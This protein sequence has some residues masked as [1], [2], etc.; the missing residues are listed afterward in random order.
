MSILRFQLYQFLD[1]PNSGNDTGVA[2][3]CYLFIPPYKGEGIHPERYNKRP[4]VNTAGNNVREYL[5]DFPVQ[6]D[7]RK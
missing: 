2:V 7:G 6:A 1:Y 3:Y 4:C 5:Q